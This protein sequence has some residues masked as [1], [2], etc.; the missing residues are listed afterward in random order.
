MPVFRVADNKNRGRLGE[1]Y[2]SNRSGTLP[3]ISNPGQP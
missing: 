1:N 3:K 2:H